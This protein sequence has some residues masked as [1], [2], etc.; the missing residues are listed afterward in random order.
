MKMDYYSRKRFNDFSMEP[1]VQNSW[2]VLIALAL[3]L[4]GIGGAV[5][6]ISQFL[7]LG[8]GII[9][10]MILLILG[11]IV[12]AIDLKVMRFWRAI[13]K[14]FSSWI[15]RGTLFISLA[16]LSSILYVAPS[17]EWFEW[18]PWT[19]NVTVNT[20]LQIISISTAILV[21]LYTGF[22]MAASPSIPFW[23]TAMLPMIF[24]V[25]SF[26]GGIS[27]ILI[28]FPLLGLLTMNIAFLESIEIMLIII[29]LFIITANLI[30]MNNGSITSKKSVHIL[31]QGKLYPHFIIGVM[32]LGLIIPLSLQIYGY[33]MG[34]V[35]NILIISGILDIVGAF[36]LRYS[37]IRAGIYRPSM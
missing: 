15:S 21:V 29:G 13:L 33:L 9:L 5:I 22:L 3:F 35:L 18:L 37:Y 4:C 20:G 34:T 16:L 11:V 28:T 31:I 14:P 8:S 12:L 6:T 26:T 2:G 19:G 23:N 27:V 10:G 1:I 7:S 17:L 25:C 30:T 36:L 32:I 24:L